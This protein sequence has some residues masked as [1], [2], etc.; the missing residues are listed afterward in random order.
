MKKLIL[1]FAISASLAQA[2]NAAPGTTPP[3]TPPAAPATPPAIP[4]PA[5]PEQK[6][7]ETTPPATGGKAEKV[8][9]FS[10]GDQ[11]TAKKISEVLQYQLKLAERAKHMKDD[12][13][14]AEWS[15]KKAKELTEKWTP[16]A[17][18]CGK[19]GFSDVATDISKKETAEIA[20][21]SKA[22][23]EKFR[24]EYLELFSKEAKSAHKDLEN[25]PKMIQNAELK[26][27]TEGLVTLLKGNAEEIENKYK[28]EKKRK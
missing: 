22:K 23:A 7:A 6:P 9:P 15:G 11:K 19:Y 18:M 4:P 26:T 12:A 16:F 5:A 24:V 14:L 20:K 13:T 28:E 10:P 8:K 17:T 25:A 1:A 2:Q 3:A 21:L 27:W